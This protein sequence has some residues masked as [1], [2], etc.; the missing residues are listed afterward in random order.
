MGGNPIKEYNS[1]GNRKQFSK[2][3][4]RSKVRK[5]GHRRKTKEEVYAERKISHLESE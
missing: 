2:L 3:R 1:T 4:F 5:V